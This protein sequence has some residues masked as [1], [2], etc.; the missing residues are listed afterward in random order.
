MS[1]N[2]ESGPDDKRTRQKKRKAEEVARAKRRATVSSNL[3]SGMSYREIQ[4]AMAARGE[5]VALGTLSKDA[6]AMIATWEQEQAAGVGAWRTLQV[7]RLDRSIYYI[8]EEVQK[9]NLGAIALLQKLIDQQGKLLGYERLLALVTLNV[10][11]ERVPEDTLDAILRGE[12]VDLATLPS[13][14]SSTKT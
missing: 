5:H 3:L 7:K 14:G 1:V 4:D 6:N 2:S 10:D 13:R 9:G 8:W 12:P 11:W